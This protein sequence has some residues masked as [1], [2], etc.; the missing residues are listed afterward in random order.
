[1]RC[2]LSPF[3][4]GVRGDEHPHRRRRIVERGLDVLPVALVH[5][6]GAA[7]AE[8][9]EDAIIG[10]PF[11]KAAGQVVEGGLVLR[12][13]DQAFVGPERGF[14]PR[15]AAGATRGLDQQLVDQHRERVEPRIRYGRLLCNRGIVQVES[16]AFERALDVANPCIQLVG[17]VSEPGAGNGR[18][19]GFALLGFAVVTRLLAERALRRRHVL[20]GGRFCTGES[21]PRPTPGVRKRRGAGEQPFAEDLDR[22]RAGPASGSR[23]P[24]HEGVDGGAERVEGGRES[25]FARVGI[26]TERLRRKPGTEARRRAPGVD[27]TLQPADHHVLYPPPHGGTH[28]AG[29][30][31]AHRVEHLQEPVNERVCPL[32]GV[33]ERKRRCSNCGATSRSM[34]H[35]SLSSPKGEGIRLWHSSTISRSQGRCGEP[36]GVRQAATNCSSTS[37]C[38]R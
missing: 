23:T 1:M 28:L 27:V 26:E 19:G 15:T 3:G 10:V 33:A 32:W 18:G 31:E 38:R 2:R 5:A 25:G 37:G 30:R 14:V 20:L 34:R 4:R 16:Q 8:Q 29:A 13:D 21:L 11:P 22:E 9:R 17:E 35:S 6:A 7:A 12:E 24:R 36:S